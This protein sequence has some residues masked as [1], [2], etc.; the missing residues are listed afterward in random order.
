MPSLEVNAYTHI[1][2]FRA[3]GNTGL[4]VRCVLFA[5]PV[6]A[7]DW[8]CAARHFDRRGKLWTFEM[9][10]LNNSSNAHQYFFQSV[11]NS[12]WTNFTD[13]AAAENEGVKPLKQPRLHKAAYSSGVIRQV[14]ENRPQRRNQQ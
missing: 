10:L 12:S 7:N 2:R 3:P 14:F 8:R 11:A 1:N 4:A 9:R 13:L 6:V 5:H